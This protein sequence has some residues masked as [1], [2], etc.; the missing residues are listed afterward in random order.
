M[1]FPSAKEFLS[2]ANKGNLIPVCKEISGDLETPVSAY[3]K[4]AKNAEYSFLFESVEGEEKIARYSFLAKDPELI[5][6]SKKRN[7]EITHFRD[8]HAQKNTLK[9]IDTQFSFLR[10]IM[11]QYKFVEIAGLPR[12]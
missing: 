2:L 7:I 8:G 10:E 11:S 12:F 1:Y 6:Q 5:F 3:M 4:I 9:I